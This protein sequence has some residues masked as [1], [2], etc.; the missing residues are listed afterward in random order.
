MTEDP[1]DPE[2]IE[3]KEAE[4]VKEKNEE[5]GEEKRGITK[6]VLLTV[7]LFCKFVIVL[8]IKFLTDLVVF[9]LLFLYRLAGLAKRRILK[10]V[11]KGPKKDDGPNGSSAINGSSAPNGS[12]G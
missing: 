10:L 3:T 9:P 7:P 4:V 6:T 2:E 11:G 5:S 1:L 8:V 12:S